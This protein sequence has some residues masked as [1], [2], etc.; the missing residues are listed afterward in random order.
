MPART[1]TTARAPAFWAAFCA[2]M[3][4]PAALPAS[5]AETPAQLRIGVV[6]AVGGRVSGVPATDRLEPFRRRLAAALQKPVTLAPQP[7]GAALVA[8]L[9]AKRV[10]YAILSAS[11]FAAAERTCACLE[12][13]AVP[14]AADGATGWRATIVVR[15]DS[16]VRDGAGL[17]GASLAVPPAEAFAART[18][19]LAALAK[20]GIAEADLGRLDTVAGGT[21]AVAAVLDRR[22]DAALVWLP[23]A[24]TARGVGAG[25]GPL[26]VLT[27]RRMLPPEG[28]RPVWESPPVPH[29]PHVVRADLPVEWRVRLRETLLHLQSDD[30][31][32][33]DAVEPELGGG[34][35]AIDKAAF[36]GLAEAL[37]AR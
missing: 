37:P 31:D 32:A 21:E 4:A 12:P 25:R 10:D 7:D 15:G 1:T 18:Y 36:D 6:S 26:A 27:E 17:K 11:A 2:A 30:P 33:Y 9:V 24:G 28:L 20:S 13:L 8:A 5:A 29:G 35:A 16:A 34:F 23:A 14:R 22:A 3:L 19:A